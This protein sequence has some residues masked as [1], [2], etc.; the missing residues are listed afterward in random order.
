MR[1]EIARL[2]G[3]L[4]HTLLRLPISEFRVLLRYYQRMHTATESTSDEGDD[5]PKDGTVVE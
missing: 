5:T 3:V 2:F 1:C 4:P